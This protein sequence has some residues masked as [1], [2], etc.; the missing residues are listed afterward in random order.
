MK[1]EYTPETDTL[2]I[3]FRKGKNVEGEDLNDRTVAFYTP[4]NELVA[5][6]IEHA[7]KSV[8][9]RTFTINGRVVPVKVLIPSKRATAK[10]KTT[11]KK[12]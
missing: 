7:R 8:N 11:R 5:L 4:E 1:V 10:K 3:E 6:E 2:Y 9:L 12:S